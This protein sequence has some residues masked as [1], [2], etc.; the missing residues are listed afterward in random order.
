MYRDLY[1]HN[2]S[3]VPVEPLLSEETDEEQED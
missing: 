2:V 3:N 1:F